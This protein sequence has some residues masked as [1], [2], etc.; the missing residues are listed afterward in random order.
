MVNCKNCGAPLSLEDAFCPN[1]GTPNPEAQDHLRKMASLNREFQKA[2]NEVHDEVRKNKKGYGVLVA[3]VMVLLANLILIPLHM[4]SYDIAEKIKVS[5]LTDEE[6]HKT[7]DTFLEEGEFVELY[8][9]TE[10]YRL[11]YQEYG[12]YN[13]IANLAYH[14]SYLLKNLT[15]YLY[16]TD[17]YTDPLVRICS[18]ISDF[19]SEYSSYLRWSD[20][21]ELMPYAERINDDFD[22]VLK[23][24]MH[25]TDQDISEAE[26]MTN[27]ELLVR[28]TE[29]LNDE[30][31]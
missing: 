16:N 31:E 3:L 29:R 20:D 7:L 13:R 18:E 21:S 5:E 23:E 30:D 26:N 6:I 8:L 24:Y 12:E 27:S 11:P 4:A 2:Q 15:N 19:K 1:C 9:F 14:Y 25:L 22:A 10:K 28:V 17:T